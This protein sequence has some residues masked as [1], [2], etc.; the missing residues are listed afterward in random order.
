MRKQLLLKQVLLSKLTRCIYQTNFFCMKCPVKRRGNGIVKKQLL[1]KIFKVV[2]LYFCKVIEI[3]II[4]LE[5]Y[6]SYFYKIVVFAWSCSWNITWLDMYLAILFLLSSYYLLLLSNQN[7]SVYLF[8]FHIPTKFMINKKK[9]LSGHLC[10]VY[11]HALK[12]FFS[13]MAFS[14]LLSPTMV[15]TFGKQ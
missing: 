11:C 15:G 6:T 4:L 5:D 3:F 8:L 9:I 12:Y 7:Q 10:D 13:R 1:K 2:H 14:K